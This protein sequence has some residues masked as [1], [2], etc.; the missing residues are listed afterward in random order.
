MTRQE[1]EEIIVALHL[2]PRELVKPKHFYESEDDEAFTPQDLY[3]ILRAHEMEPGAPEWREERSAYRVRI[4]GKCLEGRWTLVVLDLR[5]E[6][7]CVAVSIM[8]DKRGPKRK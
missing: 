5:K 3:Y 2:G 7:P 4:C 8:Q 1:A 6:G